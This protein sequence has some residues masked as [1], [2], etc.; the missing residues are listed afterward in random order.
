MPTASSMWTEKRC[1]QNRVKLVGSGGASDPLDQRATVGAKVAAYTA[2]ILNNFLD[3]ACGAWR[4]PVTPRVN[5]GGRQLSP[6]R[7][8]I[9][10][11]IRG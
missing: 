6:N 9:N 7:K 3:R 1:L 2:K 4:Q 8:N 10:I 11:S 5:T